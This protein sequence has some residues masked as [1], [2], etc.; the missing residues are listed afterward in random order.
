MVGH[1]Y[2]RVMVPPRILNP[3]G[4]RWLSFV[5]D[6][7]ASLA[8]PL[9]AVVMVG[10][11]LMAGCCANWTCPLVPI[12]LHPSGQREWRTTPAPRDFLDNGTGSALID[13]RWPSGLWTIC[14][15]GFCHPG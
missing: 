3:V 13:S 4:S 15:I 8:R 5:R 9:T 2:P 10:F 7:T 11:G 1:L 14:I 12:I 6:L